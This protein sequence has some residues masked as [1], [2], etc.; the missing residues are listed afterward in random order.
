VYDFF[1]LI[2]KF[3]VK[4]MSNTYGIYNSGTV[5]LEYWNGTIGSNELFEHQGLQDTDNNIAKNATKIVD[6]RDV[7]LDLTDQEVIQFAQTFAS[8]CSEQPMALV[9]KDRE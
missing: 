3:K 1:V 7:Q 9:I 4:Y 5:V 6:F 2:E 8:D